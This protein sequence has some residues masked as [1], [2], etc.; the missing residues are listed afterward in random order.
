M[1]KKS[2]FTERELIIIVF[3]LATVA[4][5]LFLMLISNEDNVT[6]ISIYS[7]EFNIT[8]SENF[9]D[10]C[11]SFGGTHEKYVSSVYCNIFDV[12]NIKPIISFCN[13]YSGEISYLM[14]NKKYE[15]VKCRL[16]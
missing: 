1:K 9:Y 3:M 4:L 5:G 12:E 16:K 11:M 8:I 10:D 14:Q 15:L 13:H 6:I 7:E 2:F